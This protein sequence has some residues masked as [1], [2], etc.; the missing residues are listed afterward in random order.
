MPS[1]SSHLLAGLVIA[2]FVIAFGVMTASAAAPLK[3]TN[4]NRSASRPKQLTLTCG[5]GNTVLKG[6]TWSSFGGTTAQAKGTF[7]TNTCKPNCASGKD[8]SYPASVTASSPK[9]CKGGVRVYNKLTLKFTG[10][11]PS[12]ISSQ[13]NWT[14]GCP[15]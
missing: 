15:I 2:T 10:K 11:V 3:L 1:K 9:T 7:T 8:V 13:K 4:C 12:S 6:L 14:L 5:D